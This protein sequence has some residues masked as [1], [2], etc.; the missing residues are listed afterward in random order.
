MKPRKPE[1]PFAWGR[2][3]TEDG[4]W[5]FH[6]ETAALG[7]AK[8]FYDG[9]KEIWISPVN[10]QPVPGPVIELANGHGLVADPTK[11]VELTSKEMKYAMALRDGV[12]ALLATTLQF[13]AASGVDKEA[14]TA[15]TIAVLR[16]QLAAL[17]TMP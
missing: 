17:E 14:A 6:L 9:V 3:V 7:P 8:K 11:F 13:A 2:R 12:A 15:L 4:H 1:D 5:I 10:G 16:A